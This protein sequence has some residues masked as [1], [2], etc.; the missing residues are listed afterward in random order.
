MRRAV[1]KLGYDG[2]TLGKSK[3][4]PRVSGHRRLHPQ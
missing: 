1:F 3:A 4:V 2:N